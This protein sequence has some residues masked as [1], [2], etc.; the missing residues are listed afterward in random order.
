V[1]GGARDATLDGAGSQSHSNTMSER[2][3]FVASLYA[4]SSRSKL[5]ELGLDGS[6]KSLE[7]DFE[8]LE[9]DFE[10][11]GVTIEEE[12]NDSYRSVGGPQ[13]RGRGM[14][15]GFGEEEKMEASLVPRAPSPRGGRRGGYG[16]YGGYGGGGGGDDDDDD[17]DD[18]SG[19]AKS[20]RFSSANRREKAKRLQKRASVRAISM[21][22]RRNLMDEMGGD[23]E[24]G[25][26]GGLPPNVASNGPA[27]G[28]VRHNSLSP[29]DRPKKRNSL[30]EGVANLKTL[31]ESGHIDD[32]SYQF[33]LEDM[34]ANHVSSSGNTGGGGG[35]ATASHGLDDDMVLDQYRIQALRESA[36]LVRQRVGFD[37]LRAAKERNT[38]KKDGD[39]DEDEQRKKRAAGEVRFPKMREGRAFPKPRTKEASRPDEGDAP[40]RRPYL[41]ARRSAR[42]TASGPLSPSGGG[43]S[44]GSRQD[45]IHMERAGGIVVLDSSP[46]WANG[47]EPSE[48]GSSGGNGPMSDALFASELSRI[49]AGG[50]VKLDDGERVVRCMQCRSGLKV[51]IEAALVSCPVCETVGPGTTEYGE[52]SKDGG[53]HRRESD[54]VY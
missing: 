38:K 27:C 43:G 37:P 8:S 14:R 22:S 24:G 10:S 18:M 50:K 36:A 29:S 1:L 12:G 15:G 3:S 51:G 54:E 42:P 44:E 52:E 28:S 40:G 41:A 6:H 4:E 32:K 16:G 47:G 2:S 5:K 26:G 34:K 31:Y 7:D 17:D 45:N 48:G 9:D 19:H 11:P 30:E 20:K 23:G 25:G 33:L 21:H 46:L 49:V 13:P 35:E 39:G 53:R